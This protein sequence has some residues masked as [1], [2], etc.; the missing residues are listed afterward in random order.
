MDIALLEREPVLAVCGWSGSGKTTVLEKVIPL[1]VKSGL[2]V[3]VVKHDAHG[4]DIDRE[5]KDSARFFAAGADVHLQAPEEQMCRLRR[6]PEDCLA[7]TISGLLATHDLVLVEG[8]KET[9]LSKVWCHSN[10]EEEVPDG[11]SGIKAT[12]PWHGDR[13]TALV[14]IAEE[15]IREAVA[16]RPLFGGILIGG[17]SRRMGLP[18]HTVSV[19]GRSLLSMVAAVLRSQTE[20][21]VVLG[22]GDTPDDT[23]PLDQLRDAPGSGQGPLAGLLTAFRWAPRVCWVVG[24]CDMPGISAEALAWVIDQRQPGCW[25][26][27]PRDAEGRMQPTLA[28]YE[29]QAGALINTLV[30]RGSRAP[31]ALAQWSEIHTPTIPGALSQAWLN[32]NT[33]GELQAFRESSGSS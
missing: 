4:V 14:S 6:R 21:I 18:K 1:L 22:R 12:L 33:P 10:G 24:A 11:V 8:H 20:R 2:R 9:P 19:G 26:V 3:A 29:P 28:V 17:E 23:G 16:G 5:G 13:A 25:A 7:R 15:R 32:V 30:A 27:I 31:R